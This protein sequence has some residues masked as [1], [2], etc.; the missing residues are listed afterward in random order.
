MRKITLPQ[1]L[2]FNLLLA[3]SAGLTWGLHTLTTAPWVGA[4]GDYRPIANVVLC[5]FVLFWVIVAVHRIFLALAPLRAGEVAFGSSQEFVY[6]VYI[7]FYLLVFYP[8]LRSGIPPAPFMRMLYQALGAKLGSNT[9]SQGLIHDP[10]FVRIGSN[11]TVGQSAL[12]IPHQIEGAQLAHLPIEI[13][14]NVTIGANSV[15]LPGVRIG[16]HA[17]VATGAV[18][19]KGTVIG[20]HEVWGG[21]P[22]KKIR[23]PE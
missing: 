16:N 12:I 6:H 21:V 22:A 18:V 20:D 1:I 9:Y 15:V 3:L 8:V 17:I 7:L 23:G 5:A 19:P 14:D 11:S 2:V 13:G 4:L 10:I